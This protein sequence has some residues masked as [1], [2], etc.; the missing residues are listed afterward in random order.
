MPASELPALKPA[1]SAV[2]TGG[3]PESH[4]IP[5]EFQAG[6]SMRPNEDAAMP[7]PF[8]AVETSAHASPGWHG[9]TN[10]TIT[11]SASKRLRRANGEAP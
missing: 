6:S 3:D 5:K 4:L 2:Q 8:A 1:D 10:C 7:V 11:N 9:T